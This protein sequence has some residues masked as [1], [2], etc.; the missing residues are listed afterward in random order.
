[1]PDQN[2]LELLNERVSNKPDYSISELL[3]TVLPY[4]LI[5]V[6]LKKAN[7]KKDTKIN[8]IDKEELAKLINCFSLDVI[9]TLSFDRSQVATGGVPLKEINPKTMESLNMP[10]LYLTGEILDVDGKCGGFNLGFAFITGYIAG[11]NV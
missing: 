10:G 3:E 1:M 4:Q 9:D 7:I 8:N 2:A 5:D 6:L 11:R